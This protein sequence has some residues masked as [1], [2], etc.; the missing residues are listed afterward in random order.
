[1]EPLGKI[2]LCIAGMLSECFSADWLLF[3]GEEVD[4]ALNNDMNKFTLENV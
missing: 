2:I 1:M 3:P 4:C